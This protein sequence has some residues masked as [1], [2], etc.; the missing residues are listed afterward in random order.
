[1]VSLT[2]LLLFPHLPLLDEGGISEG[3]LSKRL[4][5]RFVFLLRWVITTVY[6]FLLIAILLLFLHARGAQFEPYAMLVGTVLT[7]LILGTFGMLITQL[8]QTVSAGYIL[9]FAWF[10]LDLL[11]HGKL[12][13]RFYLFSMNTGHWNDE[14]LWLGLLAM[15]FVGL[16][17]YLIPYK[18]FI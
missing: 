2:G 10:L 14:K 13:G 1:M 18:R 4:S 12:T 16:C 8:T 7:T 6:S 5:H 17:A 3:V 11:T 15:I 9:A